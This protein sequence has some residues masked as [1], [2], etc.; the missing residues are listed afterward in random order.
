MTKPTLDEMEQLLNQDWEE[1]PIQILPDGTV[2]RVDGKRAKPLTQGT[3]L[4]GDY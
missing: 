4:G 3:P 1:P 2:I